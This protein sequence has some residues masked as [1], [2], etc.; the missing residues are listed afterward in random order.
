MLKEIKFLSSLRHENLIKLYGAWMNEPR[1][2]VVF[3][4]ELMSSGTLKE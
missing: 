3:V 4:T 1:T 2:K